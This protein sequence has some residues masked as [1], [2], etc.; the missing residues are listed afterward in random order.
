MQGLDPFLDTLGEFKD[1][2][3]IFKTYQKTTPLFDATGTVVDPAYNVTAPEFILVQGVLESGVAASINVRS[4]PAVA[5]E[6]GF[7]WIIS[8]SEGEIVF[9]SP[10]GGY[11]QGSMPDA[12]ILLKNW[13]SETEEV[14]WKTDEP[15]H[16]T[17]VFEY[18]INTARLYEA[19]ATGD[20]DGYPSIESARKVHRLIERVKKNAIWAP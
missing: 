19:F 20:E 5:D 13:K 4:T 17:S 14:K 8:G 10:A 6:T 3:A 15:A 7:K 2:Q 9:T 12:R 11:V 18:A 16:V 1:V